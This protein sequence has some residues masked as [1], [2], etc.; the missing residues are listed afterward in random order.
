MFGW[1]VARIAW[2]CVLFLVITLFT[3]VVFFV[4]PQP[5]VRAPGRGGNTDPLDIRD[6]IT[7]HGSLPEQ[8]VQFVSNFV[9]EG[10]LGRSYYN[11]QEV[12]KIVERAAPVTFSLVLGGVVFWLLI[13]IPI[14]VLSALRPR[15]LIDRAGMVFVLIGVSA[16]P[17]WLGLML[18]HVFGYTLEWMPFSGY[19]EMFSP[20]TN[21]GGPAQWVWHLILPW[22]TFAFLYAALYA[23]MIRA[24]VLETMEEDFVRTARA[25]GAGEARVLRGHVFRNSM[26]PIVTMVGM[27]LGTALGGVIFI[28]TVFG[29]PGLGGIL[30]GAITQRDLPVVLGVITYTTTAI[31]V[32]N[33]LVDILYAF[34]DPRV[35]IRTTTRTS[36][37]TRTSGASTAPAPAPAPAAPLS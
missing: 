18:G 13:A 25:K 19:C 32:I 12:S 27:D 37:G 5:Q 2:T 17:A 6:S 26:L 9:T 16:H 15:S 11:R 1:L 24:Q 35:R 3:F 30:R 21:C 4:V 36:G 28:E 20:S 29:L 7:L 34:L 10:S 8:Y 23:R 31:L 14:G 22:F 33:L